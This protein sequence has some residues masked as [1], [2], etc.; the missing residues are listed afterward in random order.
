MKNK[1]L[2]V[3][4]SLCGIC[5]VTSGCTNTCPTHQHKQ[6]GHHEQ[7]EQ[8]H[9]QKHNKH[10]HQQKMQQSETVVF[11]QNYAADDVHN[12]TA[13]METKSNNGGTAE[14]GTIQFMETDDGLKMNVD[15]MYLR[16]NTNYNVQIY[17]CGACND[18]TCCAVT[19]MNVDLPQLMIESDNRLQQSYIIRG[20][21]ATQLNNG[22]IILTRDGGHKAAWGML[23]Q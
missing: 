1:T 16:P 9:G 12:V 4:A 14:M 19:A 11:Y 5:L 10:K 3:M 2:L 8:M 13:N 18:T 21:T 20:L 22:Q 23:K 17:Q 15:L 6:H 7:N